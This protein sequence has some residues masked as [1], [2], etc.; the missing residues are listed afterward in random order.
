MLVARA[1]YRMYFRI[2]ENFAS[3]WREGDGGAGAADLED[4]LDDPHCQYL[5]DYLR[6]EED[7]VRVETLARHVVAG[8]TDTPP[9][10]VDD[11]VQR[12]VGTWLHH[13]QLPTLDEYGV[14]EF[15]AE[16]GEV[17][18]GDETVL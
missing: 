5:L 10:E 15:D 3:D 2:G 1:C 17:S 12:R 6:W 18:L 14:V 13:G 16:A 9:E 7:P 8:L 11:D 4:V